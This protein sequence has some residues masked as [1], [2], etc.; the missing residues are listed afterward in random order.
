[1]SS[2]QCLATAALPL[3][4]AQIPSLHLVATATGWE[5]GGVGNSRL[6]PV[7]FSTSFRDR[8]LNPGTV[9]AHLSFGSYE[10][11]FSV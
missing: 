11:A 1:M 5:G 8:K 4:S 9:S 2:M 7:L 3:L 10:S 6:R